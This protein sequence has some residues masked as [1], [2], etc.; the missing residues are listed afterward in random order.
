MSE[1][2]KKK[3]I[4]VEETVERADERAKNVDSESSAMN[5]ANAADDVKTNNVESQ[6]GKD[7]NKVRSDN[8][9]K[10]EEGKAEDKGKAAKA[11]AAKAAAKAERPKP[12]AERPRPATRKKDEEKEAEPKP[13]SPNQPKLDR[14]VQIIRQEVSEDAVQ[15]AYI[16]EMDRHLPCIVINREKWV[17]TSKLLKEHEEL[18][19]NYL[20]NVTGVDY[21][22]HFEVVYHLISLEK[23][24]EV[25]IKVR[26][27]DRENPSIPSV[28]PVWNTANWNE[29]EI[30]DLLGIDFPGHPNLTRIMMPDDWVGHPLRKDY[31][32]FDPEV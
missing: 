13:P 3:E 29:R 26:T 23:V 18:S 32:P 17:E 19:M 21:E 16:N 9:E 25:C 28:T 14:I 8:K 30:Y 12:A 27:E 11:A 15:E 6:E 24:E 4:N 1:E 2:Q 5:A 10:A 20:R 7:E 22:T 31:E